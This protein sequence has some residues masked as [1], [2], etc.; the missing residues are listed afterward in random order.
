MRLQ[1]NINDAMMEKLDKYCDLLSVSRSALSCML[2]GQ[3]LAQ[4]DKT[5]IISEEV[6]REIGLNLKEQISEEMKKEIEK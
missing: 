4:M 3:G 2:I 6:Y 1:V 5:F